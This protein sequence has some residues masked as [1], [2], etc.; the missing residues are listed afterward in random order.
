LRR[1]LATYQERGVKPRRP[2]PPSRWLLGLLSRWFDCRNALVG[3]RPETL[4]RRQRQGFRLLWRWKSRPGRPPIPPNLQKLIRTMSRDNPL[5]GQER[6]ANELLLKLGIRVS[7]RTVRKYMERRPRRGGHRYDRQSWATF[8]RNHAPHVVAAD[9]FTVVTAKFDLLRVLIVMEIGSRRVLHFNVTEHP[10]AQW[11]LQQFRE[12]LPWDHDFRYLIHDRDSIFS[13]SLDESLKAFG[14]EILKTPPRSPLANAHCER[15]IG[16]VRRECVDHVIP[17]GERH[18]RRILLEW[19]EHYNGGRPHSSLG[20]GLP[21][22]P[23]QMMP[24]QSLG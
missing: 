22:R 8:L 23:N 4:F 11:A 16:T 19:V 10:T 18:L 20:P 21:T 14:L 13:T 9:F 15:L 24:V 12:A 3:V 7:P 17:L 6:I 5:W 1:Q 2:D